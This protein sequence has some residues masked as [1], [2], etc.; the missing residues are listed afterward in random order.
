MNKKESHTSVRQAIM[1]RV[2]TF[3][4]GVTTLLFVFGNSASR[5]QTPGYKYQAKITPEAKAFVVVAQ[6][7]A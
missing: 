7:N 4:F 5:A 1:V 3:M 2:S 6:P